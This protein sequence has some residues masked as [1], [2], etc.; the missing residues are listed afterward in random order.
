VPHQP[1]GKNSKKRNPEKRERAAENNMSNQQQNGEASQE[2][3]PFEDAHDDTE[4]P[5]VMS[6]E[7]E[8][9]SGTHK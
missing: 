7:Q 2:Y 8:D 5:R 3:R 6:F 4:V 9:G 1:K